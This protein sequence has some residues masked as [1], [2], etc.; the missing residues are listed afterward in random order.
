MKGASVLDEI[1]DDEYRELHSVYLSRLMFN[2]IVGW[3]PETR[4]FEEYV[5]ANRGY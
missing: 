3:P 1:T 4:T 2:G 5:E